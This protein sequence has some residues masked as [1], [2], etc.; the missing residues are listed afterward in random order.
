MRLK[1]NERLWLAPETAL[2]RSYDYPILALLRGRSIFGGRVARKW[3]KTHKRSQTTVTVT[4]A[5]LE[6]SLADLAKR[7][8]A[9]L[10]ASLIDPEDGTY[11][12]TYGPAVSPKEEGIR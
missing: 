11:Q 12:L 2:N 8:C 6:H 3:R 9:I 4:R 1:R 5:E 7:K 10:A